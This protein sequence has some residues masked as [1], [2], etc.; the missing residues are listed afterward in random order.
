[1]KTQACRIVI[2]LILIVVLYWHSPVYSV[3]APEAEASVGDENGSLILKI[4]ITR[5]EAAKQFAAALELPV[6]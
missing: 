2:L 5:A 1:M 4:F 3:V 6:P